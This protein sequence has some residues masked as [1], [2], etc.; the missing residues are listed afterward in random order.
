MGKATRSRRLSSTTHQSAR[1]DLEIDIRTGGIYTR[2]ATLT[3]NFGL[4][5][6]WCSAERV[7]TARTGRL[8]DLKALL[9]IEGDTFLDSAPRWRT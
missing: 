7:P 6:A 9:H 3:L 4:M 2:S 1:I 8:R 5:R